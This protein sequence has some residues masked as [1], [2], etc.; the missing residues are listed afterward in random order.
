MLSRRAL[1]FS[2][3]WKGGQSGRLSPCLPCS[4]QLL[5]TDGVRTPHHSHQLRAFPERLQLPLP[6][7]KR[8]R[9]VDGTPVATAQ[10]AGQAHPRTLGQAG[11]AEQGYLPTALAESRLVP[12]QDAACAASALSV[13]GQALHGSVGFKEEHAGQL[14]AEEDGRLDPH[15]SAPA[16]E[17]TSDS[18]DDDCDDGTTGFD[19][20]SPVARDRWDTAG[21]QGRTTASPPWRLE[22]YEGPSPALLQDHAVQTGMS[23]EGGAGRYCDR[24]PAA[25]GTP[26][27]LA[28]A[29]AAAP[30]R[31]PHRLAVSSGPVSHAVAALRGSDS[32]PQAGPTTEA[33][34]PKAVGPPPASGAVRWSPGVDTA[35]PDALACASPAVTPF[36][37]SDA[38][39]SPH[40]GVDTAMQLPSDSHD[41]A[42]SDGAAS[43]QDG[44][45]DPSPVPVIIS[46][47]AAPPPR[48][49][50]RGNKPRNER[51]RKAANS[52]KSLAG[53]GLQ[54]D[55]GRRRSVRER[56]RPLEYWRNERKV[57]TREYRS[58]PTVHHIETKNASPSWQFVE[59]L[60][61]YGHKGSDAQNEN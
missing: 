5:G 26:S 19:D 51:L 24:R 33:C 39:D 21:H 6:S 12:D 8:M 59:D 41:D 4:A 43:V 25:S 46:H 57:Y 29:T 18:G 32:M 44:A 27:R 30:A 22:A 61:K 45:R 14:L 58:L 11:T 10:Y 16:L 9:W 48:R 54:P 47:A 50:Q 40:F 53:A 38:R 36:A 1:T 55:H 35:G 15:G 31:T 34:T 60:R 23:L 56:H 13:P 7:V 3:P 42:D 17:P 20:D 37:Q 49:R 52:R 2:R 28:L